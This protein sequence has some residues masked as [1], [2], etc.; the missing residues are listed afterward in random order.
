MTTERE[1]VTSFSCQNHV[2][3]ENLTLG[4]SIALIEVCVSD[5]RTGNK[6][7]YAFA[8]RARR[9]KEKITEN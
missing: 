6:K 7:P 1:A 4:R 5:A 8:P 2:L 3:N 9:K